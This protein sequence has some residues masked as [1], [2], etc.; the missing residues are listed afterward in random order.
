MSEKPLEFKGL[1]WFDK[2]SKFEHAYRIQLEAQ[3]QQDPSPPSRPIR[4]PC[5]GQRWRVVTTA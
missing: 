4:Q 3:Q 5:H 1:K 2:I